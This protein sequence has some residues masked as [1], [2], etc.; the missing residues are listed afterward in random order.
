M[1]PT[2]VI[3]ATQ[4]R[5]A[6]L[7]LDTGSHKVTRNSELLKV[8]GLTFDLF[9]ALI[10]S[11]PDIVT[12]D[13]VAERVW[14][15]RPVTPETIAQRAKMLRD[16]LSDDASDP[17]YLESIRGQGYRLVADV[18]MVERE[19]GT[20]RSNRKLLLVGA[21]SIAIVALFLIGT[22]IFEEETTPSVAVL[23]FTDMTQYGDQQY[24]ADGVA[25]ELID[26]LTELS[27][28]HVVSRMSSFAFRD[29]ADSLRVIGNA[30]GVT[31]LVQGS[32]RKS[33]DDIRIT[34][35]LV[36]VKSGD[37]LWSKTFDS[38]HE[39]IFVIQETI[40]SSVAG[41]LGVT[42]GVGRVNDFGG[43]GTRNFAAYEAYLQ[44]DYDLA[45]ELD[46]N[47]A[48][49]W[50]RLGVRIAS[51][52]WSNPPEK[53]PEIIDRAYPYL[54]RALELDPDSSRA[55]GQFATFVYATMDWI[56]A[57]EARAKALSL[58]RDRLNLFG[59]ANMLFRAG[60]LRKAQAIHDESQ[61]LERMPSPPRRI[62]AS[63][64]IARGEFEAA[65]EM[66]AA[67]H[68]RLRL[69]TYVLVALNT[70][71]LD[72]LRRALEAM[73]D[74]EPVK[75]ELYAPLLD[76]LDSPEQ[77]LAVLNAVFADRDNMWP[78]KYH[79][80]ALL[81][82]YF[83][84]A[85][86]ALEVFSHEMPY[87]TIRFG[88]LWYP[89]MSNVRRLPRFR[90][91]ITDVNLVEYWRAYGWADYCRPVGDEDFVCH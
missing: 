58:R 8:S 72:D 22:S 74:T 13:Q 32:V 42:L 90:Q 40:A 87:T 73:P 89:V 31:S 3:R 60:R 80:I 46:P 62:M 28:L 35:Q 59:Y 69:D 78:D 56:R 70:G 30:L 55:Q 25:E 57:E 45:I 16:A 38:N 27:G 36:D 84:D 53:A 83:G 49:A 82:A 63:Y 5:I 19:T 50:A 21:V 51:E 14:Q 37:N 77:A 66:A 85:E 86:F 71:T 1:E 34:V 6:D 68:G 88:A 12:F 54:L 20:T 24:L 11:A 61:S 81:A 91:L 15:G 79:D 23:P 44:R 41:A 2:P 67:L 43:A 76:V 47:Y 4:Y 26:E 52:M 64:H 75:A 10:E 48:A 65:R 18:E 33:D 7:V 9:L 17:R 39:D 29:T